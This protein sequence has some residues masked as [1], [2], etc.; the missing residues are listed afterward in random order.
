MIE[1]KYRVTILKGNGSVWVQSYDN[2]EHITRDLPEL[3]E[4]Y[5][6]LIISKQKRVIDD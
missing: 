5:P 4:E 2:P 3:I 6:H 1:I